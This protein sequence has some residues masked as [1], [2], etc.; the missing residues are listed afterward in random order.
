MKNYTELELGKISNYIYTLFPMHLF[1]TLILLSIFMVIFSLINNKAILN[2]NL[3]RVCDEGTTKLTTSMSST[4]NCYI[5]D[6]DEFSR[7]IKE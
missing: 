3:V 1:L 2:D 7:A 6:P 5:V 4:P